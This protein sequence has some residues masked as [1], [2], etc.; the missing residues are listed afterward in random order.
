MD[1]STRYEGETFCVGG[2][3][4]ISVLSVADGKVTL[5]LSATSQASGDDGIDAAARNRGPGVENRC[6]TL[7][8]VGVW[9]VDCWA[10]GFWEHGSRRSDFVSCEVR[11]GW[12]RL[13]GRASSYYLSRP[14]REPM[15]VVRCGEN[16]R[17]RINDAVD[18]V[19]LDIH[20][21]RSVRGLTCP[22][23]IRY[24]ARRLADRLREAQGLPVPSLSETTSPQPAFSL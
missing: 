18:L 1:I 12:I 5:G 23:P 16:Q 21:S 4:R 3:L 13:R 8:A 17:I 20:D 10:G 24:T 14:G 11:N 7:A 22:S 9:S 19:V 15:L 6:I 2:S